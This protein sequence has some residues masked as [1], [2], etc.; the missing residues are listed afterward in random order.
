MSVERVK[1]LQMNHS[2]FV[3]EKVSG[4]R[5]NHIFS[6]DP[7]ILIAKF[8]ADMEQKKKKNTNANA[9]PKGRTFFPPGI[10]QIAEISASRW[11]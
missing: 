9:K 10:V 1:H 7:H 2:D 4:G 11:V 8:L 5:T 3:V 6:Y